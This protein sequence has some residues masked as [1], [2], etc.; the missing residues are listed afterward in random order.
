MQ[1]IRSA[2]GSTRSVRATNDTP[3]TPTIR[4]P[5]GVAVPI[6]WSRPFRSLH[7]HKYDLSHRTGAVG[8]WT[9]TWNRTG[10]SVVDKVT[11]SQA[12]HALGWKLRIVLN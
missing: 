9:H 10:A 5:I 11:T 3:M 1:P 12:Y 4:G 8:I 6:G 7:K 2:S